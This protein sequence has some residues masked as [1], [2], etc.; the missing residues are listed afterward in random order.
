MEEVF[1]WGY[2]WNKVMKIVKVRVLRSVW[3]ILFKFR[4][5]IF[6]LSNLVY[7]FL[8]IMIKIDIFVIR[9]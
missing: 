5:S 4:G 6:I 8:G 1:E 9:V 7:I 2:I 3:Y